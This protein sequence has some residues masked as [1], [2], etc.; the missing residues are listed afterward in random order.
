V[1]LATA[2]RQPQRSSSR[3]GR[4]LLV[5]GAGGYGAGGAGLDRG[6]FGPGERG[7]HLHLSLHRVDSPPG[8]GGGGGGG[9][10]GGRGSSS[11]EP[12]VPAD[13]KFGDQAQRQALSGR[14]QPQP[15]QRAH[16][17]ELTRVFDF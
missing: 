8:G 3:D 11:R 2:N 15:T 1:E 12:H 4:D 10:S 16:S 7:A 9:Y 14:G 6:G 17:R 5:R 13:G